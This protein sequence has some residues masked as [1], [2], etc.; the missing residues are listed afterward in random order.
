[1]TDAR[2]AA[3]VADEIDAL[4]SVR[5]LVISAQ[6]R[7]EIAAG[8]VDRRIGWKDIAPEPGDAMPDRYIIA[9][10]DPV[11]DAVELRKCALSLAVDISV[12]PGDVVKRAGEYERFLLGVAAHPANPTVLALQGADH[13]ALRTRDNAIELTADFFAELPHDGWPIAEKARELIDALLKT[14]D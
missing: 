7:D 9:P 4:L 8:I 12:T 11:A 14:E 2:F 10:R 6:A 5:G 1:M 3:A 13:V